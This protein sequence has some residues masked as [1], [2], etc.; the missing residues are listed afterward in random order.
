MGHKLF[1]L[2]F[3]GSYGW[4]YFIFSGL[5]EKFLEVSGLMVVHDVLS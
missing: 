3:E 2:T 5:V 1:K 4:F